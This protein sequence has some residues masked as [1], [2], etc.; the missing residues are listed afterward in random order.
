MKTLFTWQ[1]VLAMSTFN[2]FS[3]AKSQRSKYLPFLLYYYCHLFYSND[4]RQLPNLITELKQHIY[5]DIG[6]Q[7]RLAKISKCIHSPHRKYT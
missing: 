1:A 2:E 3:F 5:K 6:I 7:T 4:S